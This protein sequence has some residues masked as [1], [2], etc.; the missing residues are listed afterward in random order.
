MDGAVVEGDGIPSRP[1]Q[2]LVIIAMAIDVGDFFQPV[3]FVQRRT[4]KALRA[5][6]F[7]PFV[8]A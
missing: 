5:I 4:V 7:I 3:M 6:E 8:R 1:A 2:N